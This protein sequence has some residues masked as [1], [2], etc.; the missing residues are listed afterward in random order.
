M[1][2][3]FLSLSVGGVPGGC[4]VLFLRFL[5]FVL[6]N[7]LKSV[8]SFRGLVT[9]SVRPSLSTILIAVGAKFFLFPSNSFAVFQA[10]E[11][12]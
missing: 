3:H 2:S 1:P 6:K 8:A 5:T 7:L 9:V 4:S 12:S 11:T 10:V